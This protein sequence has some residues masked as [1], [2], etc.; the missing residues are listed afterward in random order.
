MLRR[1]QPY[2]SALTL[3]TY[4]LIM[5]ISIPLLPTQGQTTHDNFI[6]CNPS[7]PIKSITPSPNPTSEPKTQDLDQTVFPKIAANPSLLAITIPKITTTQLAY[8]NENSRSIKRPPPTQ[9]P[10]TSFVI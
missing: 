4:V 7:S 8:L 5:S 2:I 6:V 1:L 9:P 10:N 3:L